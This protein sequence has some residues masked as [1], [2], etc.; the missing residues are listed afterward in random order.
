MIKLPKRVQPRKNRLPAGSSA[1]PPRFI[2]M[3]K[4]AKQ[5][6]RDRLLEATE[7]ALATGC[8]DAAEVQHLFHA[9]TCTVRPVRESASGEELRN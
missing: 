6:S 4:L 5:N 9:R 8:K 3:L 2:E 1:E 7:N